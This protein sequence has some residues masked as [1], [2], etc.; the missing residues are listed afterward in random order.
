MVET[1]GEPLLQTQ[2][3][4]K[5]NEAGV[6]WVSMRPWLA[7]RGQKVKQIAVEV[8]E[9]K[10]PIKMLQRNWEIKDLNFGGGGRV[11]KFRQCELRISGAGIKDVRK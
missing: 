10:L 1:P 9:R 8:N 7:P 3:Q 11:L 6:S 5:N 2:N 4:T